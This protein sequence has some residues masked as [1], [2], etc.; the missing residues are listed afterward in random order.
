[1]AHALAAMYPPLSTMD[2]RYAADTLTARKGQRR[3]STILLRQGS[4]LMTARQ[5]IETLGALRD[6]HVTDSDLASWLLLRESSGGSDTRDPA[7]AAE[8]VCQKLFGRL[9]ILISAG[10]RAWPARSRGWLHGRCQKSCGGCRGCP[11]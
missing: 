10:H 7:V 1:M 2:V 3:R 8:Q 9:S 6:V 4:D 5:V 11:R